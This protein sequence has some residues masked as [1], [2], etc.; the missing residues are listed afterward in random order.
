MQNT[1]NSEKNVHRTETLTAS[2]TRPKSTRRRCL[3]KPVV[4][5]LVEMAWL[6]AAAELEGEAT[7][8]CSLGS[9]DDAR[10][11]PAPKSA[12]QQYLLLKEDGD[13]VSFDPRNPRVFLCAE[14]LEQSGLWPPVYG[15]R[16]P[17]PH[18]QHHPVYSRSSFLHQPDLYTLQ[19]QHQQR[20]MEH[21]QR[22]SLGQV[23]PTRGHLEVTLQFR[24]SA[25]M[26]V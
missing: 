2:N 5:H 24:D 4:R 16:G 20:A 17:P 26:K 6:H 10:P 12:V 19:Q 18:L 23:E 8:K 3:P 21:M 9:Q 7:P 11:S 14:V 1:D 25:T 22:H 15:S 13:D